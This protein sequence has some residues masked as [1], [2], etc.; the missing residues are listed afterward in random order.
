[1][2]WDSLDW[3][4]QFG[5]ELGLR[6]AMSFVRAS[7]LFTAFTV[8]A[9]L[10][11]GLVLLIFWLSGGYAGYMEAAELQTAGT[12][13][14]LITLW[15]LALLGAVSIS[16]PFALFNGLAQGIWGALTA[17]QLNDEVIQPALTWR[18]ILLN[19]LGL[20][21]LVTLLGWVFSGDLGAAISGGFVALTAAVPVGIVAYTSI[22]DV[23]EWY[24]HSPYCPKRKRKSKRE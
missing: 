14:T 7:I 15:L 8:C 20:P 11:V 5:W 1:M 9:V 6:S 18:A 19:V 22:P 3:K 13:T 17:E 21:L 23:V 4:W 16:L 2:N 24:I 12:G 10:G